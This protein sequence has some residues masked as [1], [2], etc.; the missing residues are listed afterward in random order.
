MLTVLYINLDA[1]DESLNRWKA[2]LGLGA[3]TSLSDPKDPRKCIIKSLAMEAQGRDDIVIDLSA[4]GAVEKLKEK[5][6][7]I[8]EGSEFRMKAKFLVQH[9][10]LSGLKYVQVVKRKGV[11]V[12]KDQEMLGSYAP[13]TS[14]KPVH[15]K[16]CMCPNISC[17]VRVRSNHP[18]SQPG[19][20]PIGY[21]RTRPLHRPVTIRGRRRPDVSAI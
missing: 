7:T 1:N 10:V 14:D 11:R 17:R 16:K 2:S 19:R 3:G 8:K 6:F 5:P 9:E 13:N 12:S 15:E 21:A 18:C 4:P 20:G